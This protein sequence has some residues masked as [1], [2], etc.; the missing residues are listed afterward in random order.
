MKNILHF[1]KLASIAA[2]LMVLASCGGGGGGG[3][4]TGLFSD[5]GITA[6]QC[7]QAGIDVLVSCAGAGAIALNASQDGMV[8][9]DVSNPGNSD[10]KLGFSY[11]GVPGGCVKDNLTGLTW[12]VKTAD[13]GLRDW[14]KIYTNYG[15]N[16]GGDAGEFVAVVNNASLCG[17]SDW[18]LPTADELQSIVDYGVAYPG[19]TLDATW[20]LNTKGDVY[21]SSSPYAG[22]PSNA[23]G[24]N[25]SGGDVDHRNDRSILIYLRLVR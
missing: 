4:S 15:D 6:S 12:E 2:G 8:G 11:S 5:T 20:F 25:F 3:T 24:V 16:R 17:Y 21:W 10:G 7:Y 13:N 22:T 14:N 18:R 9:R 23:W 1:L 19:P